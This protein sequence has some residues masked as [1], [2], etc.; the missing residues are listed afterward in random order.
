MG[1]LTNKL[2]LE[3]GI[4]AYYGYSPNKRDI[5]QSTEEGSVTDVYSIGLNGKNKK[6]LIKTGTNEAL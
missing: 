6:K 5:Y 3:N 1:H 2:L 4:N